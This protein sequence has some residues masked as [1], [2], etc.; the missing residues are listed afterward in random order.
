MLGKAPL[1]HSTSVSVGSGRTSALDD[2][3][4]SEA[5]KKKE[6]VIVL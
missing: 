1:E 4:S 6:R 5:E 2:S 3:A